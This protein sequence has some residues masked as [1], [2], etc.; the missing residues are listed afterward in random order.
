MCNKINININH[1]IL[2][3]GNNEGLKNESLNILIS[4]KKF[5]LSNDPRKRQLSN[6]KLLTS[7]YDYDAIFVADV[8]GEYSRY[9]LFNTSL[10]RP[11]VGDQ[12]LKS[13]AWHWT[14]ERHGAPQLNQRFR[15]IANHYN[16]SSEDWAAWASIKSIITIIRKIKSTNIKEIKTAFSKDGIAIDT[17]KGTPSNFRFWDNQLRQAILL[18]THNA[19]IERAPVDGFLHAL[20]NLDTLGHD[21]GETQCKLNRKP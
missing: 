11:F 20:N 7:G 5:T 6:I 8:D 19:V 14:W 16:M 15:R 10:P 21:K 18:H 1:L 17:Y 9:A 4:D 12:G 2:F 3:H 13:S